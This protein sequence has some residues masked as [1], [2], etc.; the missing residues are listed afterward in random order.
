MRL[1]RCRSVALS[2]VRGTVV[3]IEV[4][5]GGMPGF[6]IVGLP[7]ASLHEARD[8]VRAA[9]LSSAELAVATDHGQPVPGGI[10]EARQSFRPRHRNGDHCCG[11]GRADADSS[12]HGASR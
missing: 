1:A 7:D 11:R 12:R 6:T 8:R 5:I 4:H 3:D 2:G 9:V 10:A